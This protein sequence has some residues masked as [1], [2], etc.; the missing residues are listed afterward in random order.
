MHFTL[1]WIRGFV[2]IFTSSIQSQCQI[3]YSNVL[4]DVLMSETEAVIRASVV[5]FV[6]LHELRFQVLT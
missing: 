1:R 5:N 2:D 4:V 3:S 6:E